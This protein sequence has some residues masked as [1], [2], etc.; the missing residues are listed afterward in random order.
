[1]NVALKYK[2]FG[3]CDVIY[4][5][6]AV[7]RR[8]TA[9]ANKDITGHL[10]L[11]GTNGTGKTSV[12]DLLPLAINGEDSHIERLDFKEFLSKDNLTEYIFNGCGWARLNGQKYII[13]F[14]EFDNASTNNLST[15]WNTLDKCGDDIMLIITTNNPMKIHPSIRSRCD[16]IEF[17]AVS[18]QRMLARAQFI[19]KNEGVILT[20]QQVLHYLKT[21]EYKGDLRAYL[22]V[23]DEI[24]YM[25]AQSLPLPPV[26][27]VTIQVKPKLVKVQ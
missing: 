27:S 9:Y 10:I 23:L 20:D 4:P 7:E 24:I 3:I 22:K 26:P 1:M 8:I 13:I 6:I 5:S 11:H 17:P 21:V 16:L 25:Q 2:P 15:F 19:L 14:H 18:A 12:A